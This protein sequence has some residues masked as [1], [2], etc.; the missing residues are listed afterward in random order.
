MEVSQHKQIQIFIK[1]NKGVFYNF[2][3]IQF[4]NNIYYHTAHKIHNQKQ[5]NI[6]SRHYCYSLKK[7]YHNR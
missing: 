1:Q 4:Y 3:Y 2:C 5:C 7:D 6:L